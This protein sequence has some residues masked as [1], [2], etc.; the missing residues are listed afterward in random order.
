MK[1]TKPAYFRAL[2]SNFIIFQRRKNANFH[3]FK[4]NQTILIYF[5]A[6]TTNKTTLT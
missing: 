2:G 1:H 5:F 3:R 4:W 6:K